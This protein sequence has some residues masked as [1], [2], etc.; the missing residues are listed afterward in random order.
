M[1]ELEEHIN[2]LKQEL[3]R[4]VVVL[5]VL[6]QLSQPRYG[7]DLIRLFGER[8]AVEIVVIA[9]RLEAR[10]DEHEAVS[11]AQALNSVRLVLGTLLMIWWPNELAAMVG[12]TIASFAS[13]M[14]A[15]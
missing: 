8:G 5:A 4:G 10:I 14:R 3:R 9:A 15:L 7:Y 12:V 13:P 2:S 6:G 1:N 11:W